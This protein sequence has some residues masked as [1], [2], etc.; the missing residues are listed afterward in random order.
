MVP[1]CGGAASALTLYVAG[2]IRQSA[3]GCAVRGGAAPGGWRP[4]RSVIREGM[5][6]KAGIGKLAL[7]GR[8]YL[9]AVQ[10]KDEGLVMYT[11]RTADEIPSMGKID[12]LDA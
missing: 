11:L 12:E 2:A 10:P 9:V 1:I 6:G 8:E 3:A 5:K 4:T 7:Y